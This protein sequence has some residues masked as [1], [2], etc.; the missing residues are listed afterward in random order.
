MASF[1]R[2]RGQDAGSLF[3]VE[4]AGGGEG[5]GARWPQ[6]AIASVF[7]VHHLHGE[8]LALHNRWPYPRIRIHRCDVI[9]LGHRVT[10]RQNASYQCQEN[11][12][13]H[14]SLL[15]PG[16][17]VHLYLR[18]AKNNRFKGEG[19]FSAV[20]DRGDRR[21]PQRSGAAV[22]TQY[23]LLGF[24]SLTVTYARDFLASARAISCGGAGARFPATR[25]A[26]RRP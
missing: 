25:A 22:G 8:R 11:D 26:C 21:E 19:S 23:R 6:T 14:E 10:A 17:H 24:A 4:A 9:R 3:P 1:P 13:P 15:S 7:I 20:V 16:M 18:M 5:G 12:I 2:S